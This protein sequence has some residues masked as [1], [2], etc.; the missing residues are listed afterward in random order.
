[1]CPHMYP[2][3]VLYPCFVPPTVDQYKPQVKMKMSNSKGL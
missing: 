1:M 3:G 2:F